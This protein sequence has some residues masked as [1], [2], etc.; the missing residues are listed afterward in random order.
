MASSEGARQR[1]RRRWLSGLDYHDHFG[2]L[3]PPEGTNFPLT[4]TRF[5][6]KWSFIHI[7]KTAVSQGKV[8][9]VL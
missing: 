1:V 9:S 4:E 6:R 2:V 8:D 3:N 5:P 7:P